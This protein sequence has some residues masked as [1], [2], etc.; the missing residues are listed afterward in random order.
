MRFSNYGPYKNRKAPHTKDYS[1]FKNVISIIRLRTRFIYIT[2][3]AHTNNRS[4]MSV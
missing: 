4:K 3:A 2:I 1:T